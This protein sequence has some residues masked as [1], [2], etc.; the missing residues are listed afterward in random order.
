M[1]FKAGA[2]TQPWAGQPTPSDPESEK[3]LEG[4][5]S[6]SSDGVCVATQS[7]VLGPSLTTGCHMV[8]AV[9][10][11]RLLPS[12]FV[13]SPRAPT[14]RHPAWG[15]VM[16]SSRGSSGPSIMFCN[17]QQSGHPLRRLFCHLSGD[18]STCAA[19]PA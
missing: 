2:G 8:G 17:R 9:L 7:V 5:N 13:P 10:P 16:G 11:V 18:W 12:G 19:C 15:S 3:T 4:V 14:Q 1:G 6:L